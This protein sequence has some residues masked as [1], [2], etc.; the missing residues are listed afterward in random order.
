ML[1]AQST[2]IFCGNSN[3]ELSKHIA[4]ELG[5]ALGNSVVKTFSDGEIAV[6]INETVRGQDIFLIQSV[7]PP[8]VN[9]AL[10]ELL[11]M[12]DA[13]K[14]ASARS[15]DVVMPYFGYNRQD[16]KAKAREPISAKLVANLLTVAGADRILTL[17]LHAKQVQG[18]FN[19][20]VDNLSG[21][22]VLAA[23]FKQM[24]ID[25][26]VVVSP[27]LNRVTLARK[28]AEKLDAPIAIVDKM[29]LECGKKVSTIIGD[30][31]GKNIIM[32]DDII[33]SAATITNAAK[34]LKEHGAED[35]YACC[36]HAIFSGDAL[37]KLG[38]SP[39]SELYI[40]DTIDHNPEALHSNI[41]VL[42][43]A[44]IFAESIRR[45]IHNESSSGLFNY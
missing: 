7:C 20:P 5:L 14:R 15:I 34:L 44:S 13:M 11:I 38:K 25:N 39:I 8:D 6:E 35:I 17:D 31:K 10:M 37:E 18:Y 19:I 26:V 29:E 33:D 1:N 21:S 30:V 27:N 42:S 9:T 36:T 41:H 28:Y 2:K 16:R 3:H 23:H 40:L 4:E 43:T 24:D 12:I 32:V 22:K 45:I